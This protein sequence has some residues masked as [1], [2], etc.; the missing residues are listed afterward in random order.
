MR[1]I[2]IW[3]VF[4]GAIG[5]FLAGKSA[6]ISVVEIITGVAYGVIAGSVIGFI[7]DRLS[8]QKKQKT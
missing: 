5:G 4:L 6:I 1:R 7:L 8:N 3:A 2:I